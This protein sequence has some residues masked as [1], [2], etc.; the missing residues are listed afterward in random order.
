MQRIRDSERGVSLLEIVIVLALLGLAAT[1]L[2]A[3]LATGLRIG[4]VLDDQTTSL[5][6][7]TNQLEDI[8][9]QSYV[10]PPVYSTTTLPEGF[11]IAF[12][13]E[14]IK[15]TLLSRITVIVSNAV[16]ELFGITTHK[17]NEQFVASPPSLLL[18]QRDFRW[19]QNVDSTTTTV[20]LADENTAYTL[21]TTEQVVR[22]SPNPPKDGLGDSP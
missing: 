15:P 2:T 9:T 4:V 19:F 12:D 8:L 6:L 20:P 13:N 17:V 7:V 3:A 11:S 22:L 10:E 18:A 21:A 5:N 16:Q 14:V 1:G